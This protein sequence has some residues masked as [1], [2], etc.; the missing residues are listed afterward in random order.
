MNIVHYGI[1]LF[2]QLSDLVN[3]FT[4]IESVR[5]IL[6][7]W[8]EIYMSHSGLWLFKCSTVSESWCFLIQRNGSICIICG[9]TFTVHHCVN[10][11][12][13]DCF[14]V[15]WIFHFLYYM[16]YIQVMSICNIPND[17]FFSKKCSYYETTI[18][19]V[20]IHYCTYLI[21]KTLLFRSSCPNMSYKTSNCGML[22]SRKSFNDLY[23]YCCECSSGGRVILFQLLQMINTLSLRMWFILKPLQVIYFLL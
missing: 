11:M 22:S 3:T 21:T 7:L 4:L 13:F 19:P 15:L 6:D 2:F 5:Y 1:F 14:Y 10:Y 12:S 23:D 18:L 9:L 8:N 16:Q 20:M 17:I